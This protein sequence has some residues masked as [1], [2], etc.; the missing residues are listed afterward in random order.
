[1]DHPRLEVAD[2]FHR[3]GEAYRQQH[4]GSL[5]RDQ[6][7]VMRAIERCRTAALGGHIEQCDQCGYQR[8]AYNSCR[9]RHC[10]KCQSLARAQWIEDRQAELL[11]T[12]YFHVVFTVP[13][14]IAAIGLQNK[15]VVYDILFR[16]TSQTLRTIAADPKHLGAEIG[17]FAVLHSWGQNLMFHPHLHCVVPGGGISPDGKCWI[18]CRPGFFLPVRLLSRLFRRLFLEL[19]EKAFEDGQLKFFSS[20]QQLQDRRAFL[21]YLAPLRK[22]EWVVYAKKPFAGPQQ[23]LDYV[24]RYTHRVAIS[25]NRILNIEHGQV[26]FRY[27]D[28]R[29]GSQQKTMTLSADE[30]IRRFLLHVLPEG[31]HRIRYYGFLGNRYRKEK[32]EQCRHL[33]GM[34]PPQPNSPT[35]VAELDYRDRYQ[36]LTGSSLWECPACHRGRMIVIGEIPPGIIPATIDTS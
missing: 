28:Y 15:E 24:G 35:E 6:L 4:A 14:E 34:V 9:D 10:P 25:N 27:K 19:L 33:L 31:F 16:A 22:N 23:V 8:H 3:Y 36:A 17:F 5:S 1:M 13:E 29:H 20:L 21:R 2:V 11:D 26:A 7:R 32:L 18:P 30:F 12:E